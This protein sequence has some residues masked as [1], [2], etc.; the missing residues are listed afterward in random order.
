MKQDALILLSEEGADITVDIR[1]V[2]NLTIVNKGQGRE[3]FGYGAL[4]GGGTS[5]LLGLLEGTADEGM[6]FFLV[7]YWL[8]V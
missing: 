1:E 3:G 5:A 7:P 8:V 4:I 6:L 2:R